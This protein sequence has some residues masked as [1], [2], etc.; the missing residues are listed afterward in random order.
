MLP[1]DTVI[2]CSFVDSMR[3]KPLRLIAAGE[4]WPSRPLLGLVE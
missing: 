1:I 4:N 2:V 3:K